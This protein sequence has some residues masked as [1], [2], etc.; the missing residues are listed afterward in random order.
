MEI[1]E[2]LTIERLV[3]AKVTR[4]GPWKTENDIAHKSMMLQ[5]E[6]STYTFAEDWEELISLTAEMRGKA[7]MAMA[8]LRGMSE[9]I[10]QRPSMCAPKT[11]ELMISKVEDKLK[12]PKLREEVE[13]LLA[14][15]G[16][17]SS[18]IE[19]VLNYQVKQEEKPNMLEITNNQILP[20]RL[21]YVVAIGYTGY[22]GGFHAAFN[23]HIQSHKTQSFSKN[24]VNYLSKLVSKQKNDFNKKFLQLFASL[25]TG[26]R[27]EIYINA[28]RI[29]LEQEEI[30]PW[31]ARLTAVICSPVQETLKQDKVD[32][33]LAL[34]D[35]EMGKTARL[36]VLLTVASFYVAHIAVLPSGHKELEWAIK[37]ARN[38][39][40]ESRV[41]DAKNVTIG[42]LA[43]RGVEYNEKFVEVH[44]FVRN[45]KAFRTRDGKLLTVLT[46]YEKAKGEEIKAVSI[47]EHLGHKGLIDTS[48]VVLSGIWKEKSNI[49]DEPILQIDRIEL[50]K[51][52]KLSWMDYIVE[53]VRPW[54]D[55]Y[56]NSHNI[57]W[58]IR[59]ETKGKESKAST[60]TGAGEIE[61]M[62]PFMYKRKGDK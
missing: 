44:G 2:E 6:V 60:L 21:K 49:A 1:N 26:S 30:I 37:A 52:K 48:Y 19:K 62:R 13:K 57:G 46:I 27:E 56:P 16:K 61:F 41:P 34:V 7:L 23:R 17:P 25:G 18:L 33:K 14:D 58:S 40:F 54:F 4:E 50:S 59:P 55:F 45:L 10:S 22:W 35:L 28:T 11:L 51:L 47:Y 24:E 38:L 32:P 29:L 36:W 3:M 15:T 8:S 20:E 9:F 42:E 5:K 12:D 53:A 31:L 43:K 39:P